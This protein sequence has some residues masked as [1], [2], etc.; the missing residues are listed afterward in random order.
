MIL[1]LVTQALVAGSAY[2]IST[3]LSSV[4]Y[5]IFGFS[6][7]YVI[8]YLARCEMTKKGNGNAFSDYELRDS[9]IVLSF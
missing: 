9:H 6:T 2:R 7:K 3:L 5:R 4:N 1:A 8:I